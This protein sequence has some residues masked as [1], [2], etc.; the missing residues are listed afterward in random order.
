MTIRVSVVVPTYRRPQLLERC[1]DALRIQIFD[2]TEYEIIVADDAG[3]AGDA[4]TAAIVSRLARLQAL[5]GPALSR[6][7]VGDVSRAHGPAAARNAGWRA[8]RGAIIAF[9]DDDCIPD[10]D[11]LRAGVAA[12]REGISGVSGRLLAPCAPRPTDYERNAARLQDAEYITANCFYRRDALESVGGFD[13][14]FRVAWREDSDLAFSL[15]ERGHR[16]VRNPDARVTHPIRP[17]PWGIS[18]RQQRY[19]MYNALLYRKHPRLYRER[20]QSAPPWRYYACVAA[21]SLGLAGLGA[22]R[23]AASVVGLGAWGA[24]TAQFCAMRLRGASKAPRHVAEMLFTSA[25]IPPLSVFW[26]IAGALRYGVV[27]L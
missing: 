1:L 2:P 8:A 17:A 27:F 19:S 22:R 21:L 24:L 11:W 26:R 18:L 15:L 20:I 10:P 16:I 6:V 9:T 12:M 4:E 3:A 7:V 5:Q 25:A 13:E 23:P 14:R